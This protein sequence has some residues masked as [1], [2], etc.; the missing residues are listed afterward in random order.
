MLRSLTLVLSCAV[1]LA[2]CGALSPIAEKPKVTVRSVSLSSASF[3]GI[4]G[5]IAMDVFNP[6]SFGVPL[7]R[8][9]WAL[10]VGG[11][12]P[13]RGSLDMNDSIPAKSSVPVTGAIRISAGAAIGITAALVSGNRTYNLQVELFFQTK[14]GEISV[15]VTHQ[16]EILQ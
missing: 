5:T 15:S 8:V 16:A 3:T 11:S 2:S 14:F 9:T 1:I 7:N 12:D 4:D 10:S 13:V 6:N